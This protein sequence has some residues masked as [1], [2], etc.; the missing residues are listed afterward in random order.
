MAQ[1]RDFTSLHGGAAAAA[2]S[3][4]SSA[5]ARA[6]H[7]D[8]AAAAAAAAASAPERAQQLNDNRYAGLDENV[9][10]RIESYLDTDSLLRAMQ[11]ATFLHRVAVKSTEPHD[12]RVVWVNNDFVN[13]EGRLAK[14]FNANPQE[15]AL[16]NVVPL[17]ARLRVTLRTDGGPTHAFRQTMCRQMSSFSR[18]LHHYRD[19]AIRVDER[20]PHINPAHT[21]VLA[22]D[23]AMSDASTPMLDPPVVTYDWA[24]VTNHGIL[25]VG[26]QPALTMETLGMYVA[27]PTWFTS[28]R[29][30]AFLRYRDAPALRTVK[31]MGDSNVGVFLGHFKVL[32][33]N[34]GTGG[35]G[36]KWPRTLALLEIVVG[37]EET[38]DAESIRNLLHAIYDL[39]GRVVLSTVRVHVRALPPNMNA[40]FASLNTGR[41]SYSSTPF[42]WNPANNAAFLP[43]HHRGADAAD[44]QFVVRPFA[45]GQAA[46]AVAAAAV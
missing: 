44:V 2:A 11:A 21:N 43:S 37:G 36:G 20:R 39:S 34:D 18:S 16:V 40:V 30:L 33:S 41:S 17:G 25:F 10:A 22:R 6:R 27:G 3:S 14:F 38:P 9:V 28:E 24:D 8:P 42:R 7:L 31:I 46:A 12:D 32:F 1:K 26:Q 23:Q 19:V 29:R 15:D 4:S 45:A 5:Y 35:G 13:M